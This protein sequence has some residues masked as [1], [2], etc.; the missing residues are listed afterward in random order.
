MPET[1]GNTFPRL[2]SLSPGAGTGNRVPAGLQGCWCGCRI[3][4][5]YR[6]TSI[7]CLWGLW[8][9]ALVMPCKPCSA[10]SVFPMLFYYQG[11]FLVA[12]LSP[13]W[14]FLTFCEKLWWVSEFWARFLPLQEERALSMPTL[15]GATSL[16]SSALGIFFYFAAA[17][18]TL[19]LLIWACPHETWLSA[20]CQLILVKVWDARGSRAINPARSFLQ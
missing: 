18:S 9:L 10:F 4:S 16:A 19:C 12:A 11:S 7:W 5:F 1:N 15:W 13:A 6:N 8:K 14:N 3:S 17:T 20:S 2:S